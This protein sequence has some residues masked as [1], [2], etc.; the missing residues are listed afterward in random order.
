MTEPKSRP[1]GWRA[2]VA[3]MRSWRTGSVALQ[4][5]ASGLPLGLIL[6]AIPDWMRSIGVDIKTVGLITLAQAPWS[7]KILWSPLMD[8]W[9]PPF[10]GRRRGWIAIAQVALLCLM[11]GLAGVG[12]HPDTPWIVGALALA[13][14]FAGATQDIAIDA[15]AVDVLRKE[16]H[17]VAVGARTALYRAA[18]ILAGNLAIWGAASVSWPLVLVGLALL[19]LPMLVVVA[20]SP[21]PPEPAV[22]PKSLRD[23]V[24]LPFLGFLSR[25]RALEILAFVVCYKLADN[26]AQALVSPFLIDMGYGPTDRGFWRGW[27]STFSTV[28]GTF[29]GGALT[30]VLGMG[31]ALWIFGFLQIASNVGYVFVADAGPN[32]WLMFSAVAVEAFTTGLGTGAFFVMLL[33][34][35]QKRFSATQYALFSSLFGIP[36][37][38][39]G[40]ICGF[41]V[42]AIG[43]KA[44]FW[45]TIAMGAPGLV[46]LARFVPWGVREIEFEVEAP[47]REPVT[48][49][50]LRIRAAL[51]GLA[52]F[53][54]AALTVATLDALKAM[55]GKADATFD[56][57]GSLAA[58]VRLDDGGA[59]LTLGGI[60]VFGAA[61]ALF[62]AAIAA[63]RSGAGGD[64]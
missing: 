52:G 53:A 57:A 63:A 36:R 48:A 10:L 49:A 12:G 31:R 18:M 54:L 24:W 61:C 26:L 35:T 20:R 8:R 1:K 62:A 13:I 9:S 38:V 55:R 23:A 27:I 21:E 16:E 64:V 60:A 44:F 32:R 2:F 17:G 3:A 6:I 33:R 28:G 30:P 25:H 19:F 7:F 5:F 58:L 51:G 39:S 42:D 56:L 59:W 43:W 34:L 37:I 29:L 14:A 41:L 15:Y 47:R 11:L 4:S 50:G 22:A 46:F 40:P 45:F